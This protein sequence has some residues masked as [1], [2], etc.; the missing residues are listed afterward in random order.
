MR[1]MYGF[2]IF[3]LFIV[4]EFS[5]F[6]SCFFFSSLQVLRVFSICLF[7]FGSLSL[8]HSVFFPS[9]SSLSNVFFC[10]LDTFC[11]S[12]LSSSVLVETKIPY[13]RRI[14][15]TRSSLSQRQRFNVSVLIH[16]F[17]FRFLSFHVRCLLR[18][19]LFLH[20]TWMLE[21]SSLLLFSCCYIFFSSCINFRRRFFSLLKCSFFLV[22]STQN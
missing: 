22:S 21:T 1:C 6:P 17:S 20:F 5:L 12:Q 16:F 7:W 14:G 9:S 8:S 11:F 19:F 2:F 4:Y 15:N 18:R 3:R 10:S 13:Q